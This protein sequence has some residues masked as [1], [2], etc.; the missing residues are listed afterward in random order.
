MGEVGLVFKQPFAEQVAFFRGKLADLVPTAHWDDLQ[1]A[2]HD[3]S[4]MVAGAAKADLLTDLAAAVDRSLSEGQSLEAFRKDFL[5]TINQRGWSGFTGDDSP[6]RRAWRT[7]IIYTTN[8]ST[9]YHAG[10]FAQL[11]AGG[12]AFWVYHHN[13]SVTHP[14]PL[15]VSWNGI[16]LPP[17]HPFWRTHYTPNGWG[18]RCFVTGSRQAGTDVPLPEGWDSIG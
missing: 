7:R 6:A 13:D 18:C 1:G 12:F 10:R 8:A 4:F 5:K 3:H 2:A 11:Q 16:T 17:G 14:R 9:S 15:H